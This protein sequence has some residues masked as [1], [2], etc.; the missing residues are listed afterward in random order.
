[1]NR[2]QGSVFFS[3]IDLKDGFFH[4]PIEE[5]N[6][7]YTAFIVPDGHYEFLKTPFGLCNSPAIFQKYINAIFR[8]LISE[9]VGLTYLDDLIILSVQSKKD[10]VDCEEYCQ[11]R[12]I[13]V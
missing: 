7:K 9:E 10:Y 6:R 12:A 5:S 11:V 8:E 13:T 3:T 4:V 2:L 1:M